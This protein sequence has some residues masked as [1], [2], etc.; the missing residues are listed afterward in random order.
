MGDYSGKQLNPQSGKHFDYSIPIGSS[1]SKV[2]S[3]QNATIAE[4]SSLLENGSIKSA[5]L[6]KAYLARIDEVNEYFRAVIET[7]PDAVE[8]A[9]VL[10]LEQ[11]TTGRRRGPLHGIPI[12]I[13]D[14][15]NT[16]DSMETTAGAL[17][18][19]GDRTHKD[20]AVVAKLRAAGAVILGKTN[21]S[22][23]GNVRTV[24]GGSGWSARGG[25]TRGAYVENMKASGSSSG[26]AVSAALGLAAAC[27]GAE[28]DSSIIS[29]SSRANVVGLKPTY[30]LISSE[31]AIPVAWNQDT[32]GPI[33]RTVADIAYL[34][35]VLAEQPNGSVNNYATSF[36][37]RD[38]SGFPTADDENLQAFQGALHVL[39]DAGAVLVPDIAFE[40]FVKYKELSRDER[41]YAMLGAFK[42]DIANYVKGLHENPQH[43]TGLDDIIQLSQRDPREGYPS[44]GID[45]FETA[46]RIDLDGQDYKEALERNVYFAGVG[47]LPGL[48]ETYNLDMIAVPAMQGPSVT[49]A[50]RAGAPAIVVPLGRYSD[51]ATLKCLTSGP[52]HYVDV[53]PNV[54]FGINF[55]GGKWSEA[56]LLRVANAFEQATQVRE[57]IPLFN[58]PK[59]EL[60]GYN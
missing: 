41:N 21:M 42:H 51:K 57:S 14:I 53:A 6:T 25:L 1:A 27:V 12:L 47:G 36:P 39:S 29:P 49:F 22:E 44:R 17:C 26:S 28:T 50:A 48:L 43:L 13:K 19:L 23:W 60:S 11:T 3:L 9:R 52:D 2:P 55:V 34:L 32:P 33:A 30:G 38:L 59:T 15:F 7:N 5:D 10:D 58:P 24:N 18:L 4:L 20:A 54:P 46:Q 40:G 56:K 31:G 8:I 45:I 37:G 35:D 16:K